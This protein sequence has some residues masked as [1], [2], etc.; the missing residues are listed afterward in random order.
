MV[1]KILDVRKCL[2]CSCTGDSRDVDAAGPPPAPTLSH[3]VFTLPVT[4]TTYSADSVF[5]RGV[6]IC[7]RTVCDGEP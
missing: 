7:E 4:F 1:R 3:S 2:E 6:S 5:G